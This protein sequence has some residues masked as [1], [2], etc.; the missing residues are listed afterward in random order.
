MSCDTMRIIGTSK[1][2]HPPNYL[3]VEDTFAAAFF[4]LGGLA[5]VIGGAASGLGGP[6]GV[7]TPDRIS[8]LAFSLLVRS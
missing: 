2:T 6:G 4:I 1:F 8:A 3:S 5:K 7:G